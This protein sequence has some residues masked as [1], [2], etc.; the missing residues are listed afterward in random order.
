MTGTP[1][2]YDE[3][4]RDIRGLIATDQSGP[5]VPLVAALLEFAELL[6]N[7]WYPPTG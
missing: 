5:L 7:Q 3:K 2:G 1:A 6:D 4:L